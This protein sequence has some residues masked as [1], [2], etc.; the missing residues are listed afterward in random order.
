MIRDLHGGGLGGH[1]GKDKTIVVVKERYYWRHMRRDVAKF[2]QRCYNCQTS[3]GQ[4]QNTGL[5]A[6][7]PVLA[8]IWEDLLMDFVLGFPRT[9]KGIDLVFIVVDRFSK[10]AHFIP[11][12]KT[13]NLS[14]IARLFFKEVVRLHG[15][16]KT[17]T[18]DQDS[19]FLGHLWKT[20]W[21]MFDLSLNFVVQHIHKRTVK[22]RWSIEL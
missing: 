3:K 16:P 20:L 5:Y 8:N 12:K 2:V 15:V 10:M 4:S 18:S 13:L 22:R 1:F 14:G 21:R 19:K 17:I 6:P 9:Q 11:C 7:L